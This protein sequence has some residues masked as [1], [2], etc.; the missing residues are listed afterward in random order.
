M[1]DACDLLFGKVG[2][3]EALIVLSVCVLGAGVHRWREWMRGSGS[4]DLRGPRGP[5]AAA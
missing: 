5:S 3:P 4:D 2:L 1:T